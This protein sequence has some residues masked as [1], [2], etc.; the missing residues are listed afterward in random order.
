MQ[1]K[2]TSLEGWPSR[3]GLVF[4]K[5][6]Q[7]YKHRA[8]CEPCQASRAQERIDRLVQWRGD[9]PGVLEAHMAK[10]AADSARWRLENP[11]EAAKLDVET[12]MRFKQW[13]KDHPEESKEIVDRLHASPKKGKAEPWLRSSGTLT[14][15][16]GRILCGEKWKQVDFVSETVW[17]E[18]DGFYHFFAL[19]APSND[20]S[21]EKATLYQERFVTIQARDAMLNEEARK[22]G[23]MLIRL[24]GSCFYTPD[25]RMFPEWQDWLS[26]MLHSPV[27]GVWCAGKLYESVPW[28]QSGCTILRS[29]TPSTISSSRMGL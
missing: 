4:E 24:A 16:G 2:N 9:N 13:H 6:K 3:C 7:L 10:V 26:R 23:V 28:A 17:V 14:W 11:E 15:D 20:N 5:R 12:G 8:T 27:P 21:G 1:R 18:V 25:G 29:P 22:R 19:P